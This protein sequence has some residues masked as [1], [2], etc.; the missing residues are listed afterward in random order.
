M[1]YKSN[2]SIN[3]YYIK[4]KNMQRHM[5]LHDPFYVAGEPFIFNGVKYLKIENDDLAGFYILLSDV[6]NISSS[7]I[8]SLFEE[9]IKNK[10]KINELLKMATFHLKEAIKI[11]N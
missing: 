11:A 6:N 8:E 5:V 9:E 10:D 7:E 4:N 2:G 1:I 3:I